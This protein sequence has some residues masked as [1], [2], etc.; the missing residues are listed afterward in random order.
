MIHCFLFEAVV[1]TR[2]LITRGDITRLQDPPFRLLLLPPIPA[3]LLRCRF[4]SRDVR[5]ALSSDITLGVF[6][7]IR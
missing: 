4:C 5:Y 7:T 1:Q 3:V 2:G 6:Y